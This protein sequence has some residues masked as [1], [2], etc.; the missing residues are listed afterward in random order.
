MKIL[1]D[2]HALLWWIRNSTRLG[3]QAR[4]LIR[5]NDTSVWVSSASIWEICIKAPIGR[6]ELLPP[7]EAELNTEMERS[8]FRPLAITFDH[9]YAVS[10]LP[11]HHRDPFDRMLIAQAR[12]ENLTLLTADAAIVAY[13]V[14]TI[15]ALH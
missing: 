11:L 13:D 14:R 3:K 2:T 12:C 5:S 15:D 1:L 6:L 7:F 10:K 4:A 9:A 8:G